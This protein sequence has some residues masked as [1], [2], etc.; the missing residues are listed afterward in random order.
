MER[1]NEIQIISLS[2]PFQYSSICDIRNNQ[3]EAE[4]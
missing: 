2:K 1:K 3:A 4:G